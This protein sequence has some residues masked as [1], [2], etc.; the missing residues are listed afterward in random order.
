MVARVRVGA[1]LE[2]QVDDRG[3][4]VLDGL[5]ERVDALAVDEAER[6]AAVDERA[7]RVEVALGRGEV[8]ARARVVVGGIRW[9]ARTQQPLH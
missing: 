5:G 2:Q 7:D 4:V 6:R 8:E 1:A 9:N 3:L